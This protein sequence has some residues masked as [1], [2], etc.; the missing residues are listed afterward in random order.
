M[1]LCYFLQIYKN[2][3]KLYLD[4][5]ENSFSFSTVFPMTS[6]LL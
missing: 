6:I 5:F 2:K 1:D 4:G 3:T